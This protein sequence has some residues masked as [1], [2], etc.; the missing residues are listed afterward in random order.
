MTRNHWT[1]HEVAKLREC[2]AT[3]PTK[4]LVAIF[5]RHTYW[6]IK[7]K[8]FQLKLRKQRGYRKPRPKIKWVRAEAKSNRWL[9]ICAAHKP[10]VFGFGA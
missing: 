5:P 7:D 9:E 10:T 8:S 4:E 2:F 1:N 6:G 3:T